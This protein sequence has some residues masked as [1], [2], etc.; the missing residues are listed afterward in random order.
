MSNCI[1]CGQCNRTYKFLF[2]LILFSLLKDLAFGSDN[3]AIFLYFKVLDFESVSNC[4]I[5]RQTICYFF[6]IIVAFILYKK[7]S[8]FIDDEKNN[9]SAKKLD[10]N[11]IDRDT[12]LAGDVELI[13]N[14]QTLV[15]YPDKYLIII[16]FLWILEEQLLSVFKDVFLHLDF[17]MIELIIV[18]HFMKKMLKMK[19]YSHQR[20]MLWFCI[21]P[22]MLKIATIILSFLDENNCYTK[23]DVD[24][25]YS[26]SKD[27]K[28][29][30]LIYIAIPWLSVIVLPY[31]VLIIYRSYVNTKLKWLMDLK[32]VSISKIFLF[33]S[34][35][36]FIHNLVICLISTFIPCGESESDYSIL[37]YFCKVKNGNKRFY[38][39]FDVYFSN[40][41][42]DSDCYKEFIALILG[43]AFFI[44]Y[45]FF[46]LKIIQRMTP[47]HIIFSFPIFYI[48]NKSYLLLL[49]YFYSDKKFCYLDVEY[50]KEKLI[51]DYSSDI[52]SIIG[53][54]IYLEIIELHFCKFDYN[55]RRNILYRCLSKSNKTE[56]NTS[57]KSEES[58]NENE[59]N[60]FSEKEE[61]EKYE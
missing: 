4:A 47:V 10:I 39:N 3:V 8:K 19:V 21:V 61:E 12:T 18:H 2:F 44:L 30:K 5:V 56:L 1:K 54:L 35:I 60:S 20:L 46:N 33:Y 27:I 26:K 6:S 50:A 24:Y 32:F 36:G 58:E 9:K 11:E 38:D 14:E 45:K 25:Q 34:I 57:I 29:L 52:V 28:K 15:E 40:L 55:I 17:W 22:I 53:Y 23:N 59:K 48:F 31:F 43:I 37:D 16:I 41:F 13:H 51:L 49:N 7:E 42:S